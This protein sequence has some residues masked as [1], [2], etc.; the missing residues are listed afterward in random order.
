MARHGEYVVPIRQ[1]DPR[2]EHATGG[3]AIH[4]QAIDPLRPGG[5]GRGQLK[6]AFAHNNELVSH[7]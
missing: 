1:I 7:F 4:Q 5:R 2:S 6:Q 3:R